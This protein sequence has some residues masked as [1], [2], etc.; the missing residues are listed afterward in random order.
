MDLD[1]FVCNPVEN[2]TTMEEFTAEELSGDAEFVAL[3]LPDHGG[4]EEDETMDDDDTLA[5]FTT[6]DKAAAICFVIYMLT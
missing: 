1:E 4:S 3:A 6:D 2:E 5:A